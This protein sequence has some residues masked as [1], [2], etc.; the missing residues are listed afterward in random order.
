MLAIILASLSASTNQVDGN[1]SV[2]STEDGP[3]ENFSNIEVI[4]I[5]SYKTIAIPTS[6]G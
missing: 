3:V 5:K 1:F 2:N 4:T 6:R